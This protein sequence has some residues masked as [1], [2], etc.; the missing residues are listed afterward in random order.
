MLM[1]MIRT[2]W[3]LSTAID[4]WTLNWKREVYLWFQISDID[5]EPKDKTKPIYKQFAKFEYWWL[6]DVESWEFSY[7][8]HGLWCDD[9][10][11][12]VVWAV[13]TICDIEYEIW[14]YQWK[15]Q[16]IVRQVLK[17]TIECNVSDRWV[18]TKSFLVTDNMTKKDVDAL[19]F[20]WKH[21]KNSD[22]YHAMIKR[23]VES[24]DLIF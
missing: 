2:S 21:L 7:I 19:W 1:P 20:D 15:P 13:W 18:E 23:I 10:I 14:E 24:D 3:R 17:N 9:N 16:Y 5:V 8:C 12:W 22:E 4:C 11:E 6:I